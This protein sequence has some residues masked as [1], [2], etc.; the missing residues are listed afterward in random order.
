ME[1]FAGA[2]ATVS[3]DGLVRV[4]STASVLVAL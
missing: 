2:V 3:V 1:M 4:G